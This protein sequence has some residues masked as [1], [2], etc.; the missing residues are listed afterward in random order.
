MGG[1][2]LYFEDID[3]HAATYEYIAGPNLQEKLEKGKIAPQEHTHS[4]LSH[5]LTTLRD[6]HTLGWFHTDLSAKDVILPSDSSD[7]V[8]LVCGWS[9]AASI[10][11][12]VDPGASL[13]ACARALPAEPFADVEAE[14][15]RKS[16]EFAENVADE[17]SPRGQTA[18]R[19]DL[20]EGFVSGREVAAP[21]IYAAPEQFLTLFAGRAY[22]TPATDVYRAAAVA[23]MATCGSAPLGVQGKPVDRNAAPQ[24]SALRRFCKQ[25][26]QRRAECGEK[27]LLPSNA[28]VVAFADHLEKLVGGSSNLIGC[29]APEL[30]SWF[31]RALMRES[32]ARIQTAS[33]ALEELDSAW[34]VY[35]LRLAKEAQGIDEQ[36]LSQKSEQKRNRIVFEPPPELAEMTV[37]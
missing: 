14:E 30:T 9:R 28:E 25:A 35:E 33:D 23:L 31:S 37:L 8:G 7:S 24:I 20:G 11:E 15:A 4:I 22:V 5:M 32:R 18:L 2:P 19:E 13:V 6:A 1:Q 16:N 26:I 36:R 21:S 27:G 34:S 17:V 29:K 3:V 12:T 10:K